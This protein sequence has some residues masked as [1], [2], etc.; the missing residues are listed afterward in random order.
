MENRR[1]TVYKILEDVFDRN[2]TLMDAY[3]KHTCDM[4]S[5]DAG[6]VKELAYGTMRTK[7]TLD[8]MFFNATGKKMTD[9]SKKAKHIVRMSLYE[10]IYMD[11][12]DYAVISSA[13]DIAK[14]FLKND[15]KFINWALREFLR[16]DSKTDLPKGDGKEALSV[17]YSFPVHFVEYLISEVG[18]ERAKHLMEFYNAKPVH[19]A[20]NL[21]T[22]SYQEFGDGYSLSSDEYVLDPIYLN[23]FRFLQLENI[24]TV[25][26]C[27]A[28]PGGKSFLVKSF[29]KGAE[30]TAIDEDPERIEIMRSNIKRLKLDDIEL[31]ALNL[32]ESSI[33]KVFDLV[34]V[35]VP[36]TATGTIRKNPD[37]KYNYRRKLEH[38]TQLQYQM[39][40]KSDDYV[41][42][43]GFVLYT[44]CSVMS[45]ENYGIVSKYLSHHKDYKLYSQYFS[46]GSPFNGGYGALLRKSGG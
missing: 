13:V 1:L 17:R 18:A 34:I 29:I 14:E 40:K 7:F 38:L 41:K 27:C 37:V 39:L 43:G 10:L 45:E 21:K 42:D 8:W 26:D 46:F 36:C 11:H 22:A 25:L 2:H 9:V 44:T 6:F 5:S 30:I 19:Y 15:D 32:L 24:K 31:K 23:M 33:E 12:K 20:F 16:K 4:R 3:K 35:D 28:A